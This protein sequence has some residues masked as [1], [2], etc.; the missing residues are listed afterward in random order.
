[1]IADHAHCSPHFPRDLR[2]RLLGPHAPTRL[3]VVVVGPRCSA[4]GG[5]PNNS[6]IRSSPKKPMKNMALI[7]GVSASEASVSGRLRGGSLLKG[8][9]FRECRS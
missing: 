6:S 1:M 3:G 7:S 9:G 8:I 5:R 4:S 2:D